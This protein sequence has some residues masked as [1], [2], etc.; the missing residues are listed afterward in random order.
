MCRYALFTVHPRECISPKLIV[1]NIASPAMIIVEEDDGAPDPL[2]ILA[3]NQVIT[4]RLNLCVLV[5]MFLS[6]FYLFFSFSFSLVLASTR[7]FH[8]ASFPDSPPTHTH[9]NGRRE[10]G[11]Y[12]ITRVTAVRETL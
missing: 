6:L 8:I 11:E 1:A 10:R 5:C 4:L 3:H 7:T 12:F 2:D 9:E